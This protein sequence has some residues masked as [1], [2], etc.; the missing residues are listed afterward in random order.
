MLMRK[1][2]I[3]FSFV[4]GLFLFVPFV[5]NVF[6]ASLS[7]DPATITTSVGQ[8]FQVKVNVDSGTDKISAVDARILYDQTLIDAQDVTNGTFFP[9]FSKYISHDGKLYA[10]GM[11]SS[12]AN[13]KS[14]A[15]TV[16]IVQFIALKAGTAN[17]TFDCTDAGSTRDSNIAKNDTNGTDIIQCST[18]GKAVVTISGSGGAGTSLTPTVSFGATTITPTTITQLART[19]TLDNVVRYSIFGGALLFIGFAAKFLIL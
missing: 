3:E 2:I 7:F 19:G 17:L 12:S 18:N 1:K 10:E 15:G 11:V 16:A 8:T 5:K 14:G 4:L 9:T 6:A 13:S